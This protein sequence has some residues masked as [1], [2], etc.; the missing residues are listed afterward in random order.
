MLHPRMIH[1]FCTCEVDLHQKLTAVID[2]TS[3]TT[4]TL[5]HQVR[6][7][8]RLLPLSNTSG[9]SVGHEME[10]TVTERASWFDFLHL[11]RLCSTWLEP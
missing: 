9:I 11:A 7:R 4:L 6:H 8:I 5:A 1:L 2:L 3:P 10:L